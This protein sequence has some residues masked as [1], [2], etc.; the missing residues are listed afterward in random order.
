MAGN[1]RQKQKYGTGRLFALAMGVSLCA[2]AASPA[3]ANVAGNPGFEETIG[4]GVARNWDSTNGATQVNNAT[5]GGLGF[6]NAPEGSFV[7]RIPDATFTFQ[8]FDNVKPGDFVTFSAQAQSTTVGAANGGRLKIDFKQVRPDGTDFLINSVLSSTLANTTT[9]PA[10][11]GTYTTLTVSG[12]APTN[13]GRVVFVF[14]T[15][16]GAGG[17]NAFDNVIAEVR[18]AKMQVLMSKSTVSV[19]EP[20][21]MRVQY[22]NASGEA[23][24]NLNLYVDLPPG[25]RADEASVRLN[26]MKASTREGSLIVGVG[27]I[28]AGETMN[29]G[30]VLVPT[31]AVA[32][33][34]TYVLEFV[35]NNGFELSER[36]RVQLTVK[37]DPVFD[38]G[39]IIG[40]VFHDANQN[41]VQDEGELGVPWVKL[42]TEEGI[43]VVTDE[44]GRYHIPAAKPGRHLIKIDGHSLPDGTKFIT[45][46]TYLVKT[47]PGILSKANFAVLLPPSEIPADFQEELTVRF[48]QGLDTSHPSL[49]VDLEPQVLMAGLGYLEKEAVF[50]FHLNYP[51]FVKSWFLEIRDEAGSEIWTGYGVSAPPAEVTWSGQTEQGLLIKPGIY[52]YQFKVEDQEGRQ[53]WTPLN[54][55]RVFSKSDPAYK[56]E[57]LP[58][59]SPVGDF[60]IF[61]D[62]KAS[63]PLVAKPT[64]RIEGKTRKDYTVSVN[65]HEVPVDGTTGRFTTEFYVSPGE[66]DYLVEARSP[67]GEITS[68]RKTM[69]VK[70]SQFFMVALGEEQLGY[71][72]GSGNLE[73]AGAEGDTR[74][75]FYE[76]GRLSY[77]MKGKIKG[78]ILVQSH[79]DTDDR[80]SGF[81]RNLD[82]DDYYPV[83]GDD[84]SRD[85]EAINTRQRFYLLV[86]KDRSY[87]K[88]GSYETGF[89]DTELATYNRTLSGFKASYEDPKSTIYGD[90]KKAV[91]VFLAKAEHRADHNEFAATGGSLYYLRNRNILEGSEKVRV[92]A[93]DKIQD[94]SI[95]SYDLKEGIDYEIDYSEGRILLSRPLSSVAASDTLVNSDILDG[96]P[97]YLIV[98]Y[99]FDAGDSV[100][101]TRTGASGATRIWEIICGSA[102]RPCR[103]NGISVMAGI[104]T[105]AGWT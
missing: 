73:A 71:N 74:R 96:S 24:N 28:A 15:T 100:F 27:N 99:E 2:V 69:L 17:N 61:K 36:S 11:G 66:K 41:E 33:G 67:Q 52:S 44:H 20:V 32:I 9:A 10:G 42:V 1:L 34:Q 37:A 70:D 98:D 26:G 79:Y 77:Y 82:P 92:E 85:Y 94:I 12:L 19:G 31:S 53:D 84:S 87:V 38:E 48:T 101:R 103:K 76:N 91:K 22:N 43:I 93:R 88:W 78:K 14:E 16:G 95:D 30:F 40:K 64:V 60:N 47:T 8:T 63:I 51:D 65:G 55:F 86:E 3:Y 89:N 4:N 68:Y 18:P 56:Q 49:G 54:F 35:L 97:V 39:T 80:R 45:E 104:T 5:L 13:C 105:C 75:D 23:L 72:F 90:P 102:P 6:D 62:G 57:Q 81:F 46:S 83:Y 50:S 59:I 21:A 25:F 58:E 29:V 7:L